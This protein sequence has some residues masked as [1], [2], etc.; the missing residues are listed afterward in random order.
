MEDVPAKSRYHEPRTEYSF[1]LSAP[2]PAAVATLVFVTGNHAAAFALSHVGGAGTVMKITATKGESK[3]TS[4]YA[5]LYQSSD[6]WVVVLNSKVSGDSAYAAVEFLLSVAHPTTVI[7]LDSLLETDYV[8]GG[9]GV[10]Y[11]A[12]SLA[13][14]QVPQDALL[15]PGNVLQGMSAASVLLCEAKR[16]PAIAIA[17]LAPD[18]VLSSSVCQLFQQAALL[19]P[20]LSSSPYS[21]GIALVERTIYSHNIYS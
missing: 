21:K 7:A 4:D 18:H 6:H 5:T 1:S 12:N 16:I 15:A 2:A 19:R 17:V 11:L 20:I 8:G 10:R 14:N 9:S 13:K 3:S